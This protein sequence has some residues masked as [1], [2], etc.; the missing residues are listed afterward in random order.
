[1]TVPEPIIEVIDVLVKSENSNR[2]EIINAILE[3]ALIR[4]PD[5]FADLL[6]A[7]GGTG[8]VLRGFSRI[9]EKVK[10]ETV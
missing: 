4:K 9:N 7:S 10:K 1:M 3:E 6:S 5:L 8:L 2:S